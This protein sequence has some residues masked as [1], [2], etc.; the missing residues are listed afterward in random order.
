MYKASQIV[1]VAYC[2]IIVYI[3]NLKMLRGVILSLLGCSL[4]LLFQVFIVMVNI[5]LNIFRILEVI[6]NNVD[7]YIYDKETQRPNRHKKLGRM[8]LKN[9]CDLWPVYLEKITLCDMT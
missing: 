8:H 6:S 5:L 4:Q 9:M 2:R 7:Y 3:V 1:C